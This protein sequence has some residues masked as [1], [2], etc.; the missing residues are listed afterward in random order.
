[1][2]RRARGLVMAG[3]AAGAVAA[4]SCGN[5]DPTT[6]LLSIKNGDGVT[7]PSEVHL[8]V[9]DR[10]GRLFL[11]ARLPADGTLTPAGLP[12]LGTVVLYVKNPSELR[13]DARGFATGQSASEGTARC[14]PQADH[15]IA[16]DLVLEG[17]ALP[18]SDTDGVP[19]DIDNCVFL[20][21]GSQIDT[22]ADGVGDPCAGSDG[23]I[24]GGARNGSACST[25]MGCDSQHC[26]DGFCCDTDCAELCHSCALPGTLGTCTAIAEGNDAQGD[27]PT[28]PA[29]SCGHTG[30]CGPASTCAL[31][32]DGQECAAAACMMSSQ[33]SSR[34][35]DGTG[36]CRSAAVTDCGIY[37][38]SG[39]ACATTCSSDAQCAAGYYCAAPECVPKLDVGTAC[40]AGN[41]CSSGFCADGICC[42][43][44]CSG[45]CKSCVVPTVGTCTNYAAGTDPD[46]ECTQGLACTGAG[47]CFTRCT[48]DAPDCETGFYCGANAC[49]RM[50]ANGTACAANN[51]CTSGFCTDGVCCG[52]ACTE[53]CKSCNLTG[54]LGECTFVP[55]GNRDTSGTN[56]CNPPKRCD[57]AGLCQ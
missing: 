53:T 28:E 45:A 24:N 38:C 19:D 33:T 8:N 26:V 55:N 32:A 2:K 4:A 12:L 35:C 18:D 27:C 13:M 5:S 3:I 17:G 46:A 10:S 42:A 7:V 15:Q 39:K 47:A 48:K 22:D 54:T 40:T 30:K 36:T 9:F 37:S 50:K 44:D 49:Q 31:Y 25:N 14:S 51:E 20:S 56:P 34:T 21:N 6:V 52:E 23:G 1:V 57:G 29:T 11:N 41:Q 43:T 16:A